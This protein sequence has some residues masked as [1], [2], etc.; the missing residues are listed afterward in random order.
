[1]PPIVLTLLPRVVAD[2]E[3]SEAVEARVHVGQVGLQQ[4]V[5]QDG[6]ES[7]GVE[8]PRAARQHH[9]LEVQAADGRHQAVRHLLEGAGGPQV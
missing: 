5:E 6:E 2:G 9:R 8:R 4:R 7:V 3:V 1:M